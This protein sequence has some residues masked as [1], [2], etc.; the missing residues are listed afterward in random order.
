M[1]RVAIRGSTGDAK[2]RDISI[3]IGFWQRLIERED[4][5]I[6]YTVYDFCFELFFV[7]GFHTI[8]K[9][10]GS[11]RPRKGGSAQKTAHS[12]NDR[13]GVIHSPS[14][15]EDCIMRV[16]GGSGGGAGG[17]GGLPSPYV[18]WERVRVSLSTRPFFPRAREGGR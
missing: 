9:Q 6:E 1:S 10:F 16:K 18:K 14:A 5:F 13:L 12:A 11:S 8:S 7:T 15:L 2:A 3:E 17:A 4:I